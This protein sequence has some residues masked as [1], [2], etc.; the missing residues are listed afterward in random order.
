MRYIC[1]NCDNELKE[2]STFCPKCGY[3]V[4]RQLGITVSFDEKGIVKPLRMA[5]IN[6]KEIELSN[7][8]VKEISE[9][10]VEHKTDKYTTLTYNGCDVCRI[11]YVYGDIRLQLS[12]SNEDREKYREHPFFEIQDNK[13]VNFWKCVYKDSAFDFY[14]S[15]IKNAM[16]MYDSFKK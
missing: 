6:P 12:P 16:C 11:E 10:K 15:V 8:F 5:Y 3:C 7:R 4:I 1:S 2:D 13:N 14:I 9:L